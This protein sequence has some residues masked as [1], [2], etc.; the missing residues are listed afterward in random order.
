MTLTDEDTNSIL[1]DN[2]FY[3]SPS[4]KSATCSKRGGG[5]GGGVAFEQSFGGGWFPKTGFDLT[6]N[7][8]LKKDCSFT[9]L[10]REVNR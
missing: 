4:E 5:G 9:S 2:A 6:K 1:T 8:L 7:T 3:K 10:K